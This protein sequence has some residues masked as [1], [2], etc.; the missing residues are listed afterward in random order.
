MYRVPVYCG[1]RMGLD[2]WERCQLYC[3]AGRMEG[4]QM[5][6]QNLSGW[7]SYISSICDAEL[8]EYVCK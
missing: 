7:N 6:F 5:A 2:N 1:K 4:R 3:D 8:M